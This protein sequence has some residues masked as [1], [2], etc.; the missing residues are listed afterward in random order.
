[1]ENSTFHQHFRYRGHEAG[2]VILV[3]RHLISGNLYV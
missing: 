3:R 1:L 2:G